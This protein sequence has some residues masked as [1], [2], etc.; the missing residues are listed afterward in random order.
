MKE[1][2]SKIWKLAKPY[3]EK[4]RPTD[5]DHIEWMMQDAE[6]LCK[7]EKL[8]DSILLP[9]VILHDVGYAEVPKNNSFNLNLREAHMKTGS[10]IAKRILEKI[11]YPK[12]KSDK[13]VHLVSIHDSWAFGSHELYKQDIILG[14]FNDLDYIWMATPKGFPALMKML[15]KDS[16]QMIDYLENDD[17]LKLRPFSTKTAKNIYEKYL[18]D[19]K[20]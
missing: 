15:N 20:K 12:D 9:L 2:Y 7:K 17:K 4:G 3:Y 10:I 11:N 1:V 14:T 16:K 13:I 19:R 6:I 18:G 8:D 5:I